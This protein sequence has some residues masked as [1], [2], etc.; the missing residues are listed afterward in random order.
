[1]HSPSFIPTQATPK[2]IPL[3]QTT[4]SGHFSTCRKYKK[5]RVKIL[6]DS[7]E[8]EI[9]IEIL[10]VVD[11]GLVHLRASPLLCAAQRDKAVQVERV[12]ST[13]PSLKSS[14][15]HSADNPYLLKKLFSAGSK[16]KQM[17]I[18]FGGFAPLR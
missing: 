15:S 8:G 12:K 16:R 11:D 6:F 9:E 10:V 13:H 2:H 14:F 7:G 18:L 4:F 1:M 17:K 5:S 3:G